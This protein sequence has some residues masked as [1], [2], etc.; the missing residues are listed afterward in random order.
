MIA[1]SI[2][3]SESIKA[4]IFGLLMGLREIKR[5][6][7]QDV[8]IDG[9]SKVVIRWGSGKGEG[10]WR[11]GHYIHEIRDLVMSLGIDLVHIS[12]DRN[13]LT[14]KLANWG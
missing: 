6:G 2:A 10:S 8:Y 7:I 1:N 9:D 14:G 13:V 5:M 11:Y 12:G 4:E 3:S